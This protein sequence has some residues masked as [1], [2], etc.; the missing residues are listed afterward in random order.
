[1]FSKTPDPT[2]APA[3][4]PAV[5]NRATSGGNTR[6]VLAQDLRITGEISSTGTIEVLGEIEGNLTARG[7]VVGAEGRMTG[8]VSA[9]TVEVKGRLDGRVAT[10]NFALRSSAEVAAD[11]TYTTLVIES[12]AQIEGKFTLN[13]V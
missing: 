11:I 5:Q 4:P 12:G 1:M 13:K 9:E 10:I 3:Q 2:T 8:T 6:S 7:L